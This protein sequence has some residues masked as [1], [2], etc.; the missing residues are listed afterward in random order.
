LTDKIAT[1]ENS[2]GHKT[3]HHLLT[4]MKRTVALRRLLPLTQSCR[5]ITPTVRITYTSFI[6]SCN[7]LF[8]KN[9]NN[10]V[11]QLFVIFKDNSSVR[12]NCICRDS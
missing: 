2:K 11:D 4:F 12:I 7:I 5:C 6:A 3:G 10:L 9:I 1:C 8:E